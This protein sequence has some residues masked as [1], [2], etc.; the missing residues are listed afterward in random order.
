MDTQKKSVKRLLVGVITSAALILPLSLFA[1]SAQASM[2]SRDVRGNLPARA[3]EMV[4][5][6]PQVQPSIHPAVRQ[7]QIDARVLSLTER[8]INPVL[9]M[10]KPINTNS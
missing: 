4:G 5:Q 8:A 9:N 1:G 10:N 6:H 7:T 2:G 3:A